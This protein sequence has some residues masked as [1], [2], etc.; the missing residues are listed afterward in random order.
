MAA[1][2]PPY[3]RPE[4]VRGEQCAVG[5]AWPPVERPSNW[6]DSAAGSPARWQV[7]SPPSRPARRVPRVPPT[8]TRFAVRAASWSPG[9]PDAHHELG[10]PVRIRVS[11]VRPSSVRCPLRV[12]RPPVR[13]PA[14]DIHACDVHDPLSNVRVWTSGAPRRCPR[15]PRPRPPVCTRDFVECVGART[16]T[17]PRRASSGHPAVSADGST[18]CLSQ[19]ASGPACLASHRAH[20]SDQR[21]PLRS[22]VIVG[23]PGPGRLVAGELLSWTA[24]CARGRSAAAN[25]Q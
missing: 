2:T 3:A 21:R 18:I 14:T 20:S 22:V 12:Q 5:A 19:L 10:R 17:R 24:T 4:I 23:G 8:A 7:A 11:S 6:L 15:V 9:C 13:C 1:A 16:T 25:M